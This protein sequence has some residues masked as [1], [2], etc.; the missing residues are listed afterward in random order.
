M[1]LSNALDTS[2]AS[3]SLSIANIFLDKLRAEDTFYI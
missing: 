3:G 1:T 2:L